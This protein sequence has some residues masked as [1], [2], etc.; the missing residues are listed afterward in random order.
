MPAIGRDWAHL[1]IT[2]V[3]NTLFDFGMYAEAGLR[4]VLPTA[5]DLLKIPESVVASEVREA[6][7]HFNSVEIPYA[8]E[9]MPSLV[10]R[11]P[12]ERHALSKQLNEA[13]W[14]GASKQMAPYPGVAS[15]MQH[16]QCNGTAI[17]AVSDA[18]LRAAWRKLRALDLI[19]YFAGVVG[20]GPLTRRRDPVLTRAD[21]PE[22]FD[23]SRS[24]HRFYKHL[25]N[26]ERKPSVLAYQSVLD[27]IRIPREK[28]TVV[29]DSPVNDLEPARRLGLSAYWAAYGERN[30]HLETVL[31]SVTPFEPPEAVESQAGAAS[32]FPSIES[33]E[34]L[35]EIIPVRQPRLPRGSSHD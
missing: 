27:E 35:E 18:P 31:K 29:G 34:E 25:R 28:I 23:P 9:V 32:E 2:D 3:D 6:F 15:T 8:F 5:R 20:V 11:P 26:E 1:L 22:Y 4:Q 21:I 19:Q 33:F 24:S 16:L 10:E 7:G 12:E 14:E 17:V 30:R 13:F